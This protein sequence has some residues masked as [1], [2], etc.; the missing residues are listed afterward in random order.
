MNGRGV[1]YYQC[2]GNRSGSCGKRHA[3]LQATAWCLNAHRS[4]C[5]RQHKV[6]D[7]EAVRVGGDTWRE[8]YP[9]EVDRLYEMLD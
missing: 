8:L 2:R 7:R 1:L 6:A 4:K 5:R 9:W 3:T